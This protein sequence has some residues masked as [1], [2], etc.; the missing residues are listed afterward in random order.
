MPIS[1]VNNQLPS[2]HQVTPTANQSAAYGHDRTATDFKKILQTQAG[3]PQPPATT[4]RLQSEKIFLGTINENSPTVS[5]LLINN[6]TMKKDAWNIIL[7]AI[8]KDK[9]F[10]AIPKGD[11]VEIDLRTNE[12]SWHKPKREAPIIP[13]EVMAKQDFTDDNQI[14]IGK[15]SN[16]SPTVSHLLRHNKIYH[17][18][19]WNIILSDIN[20]DKPYKSLP[21]GT[22]IA[23]NPQTFELSFSHGSTKIASKSKAISSAAQEHLA[24]MADDF[25][26]ENKPFSQQLVDSVRSYIGKP[27]NQIDCYGLLVRGLKNQGI[28]YGGSGGL[29][30]NL[31]QLAEQHNEPLNAYQNGEGLIKMAGKTIFS[32]SFNKV[33]HP[34]NLS[35]S[36][37]AEMKP[38][39]HEGMIL[40]FSTPS[41][42]HTGIIAKD[43]GQWTY[44]NSGLIDHAL[45]AGKISRRVGE[46]SLPDEITN[47]FK[48]AEERHESLKVSMGMLNEQKLRQAGGESRYAKNDAVAR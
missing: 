40:S 12:I 6:S 37:F 39:L 38:K 7:S 41:R 42:G 45:D 25:F 32:K 43:N 33:T 21:N 47:W 2:H 16:D 35:A 46:E 36:T 17:D 15:I 18:E 44:I 48:L 11:E 27:Y 3:Q 31:E 14:I 34:I 24:A 9:N 19:A 10:R 20:S 28:H 5:H 4:N 26:A 22:I 23:I 29:R 30:E 1:S 13:P 8:N